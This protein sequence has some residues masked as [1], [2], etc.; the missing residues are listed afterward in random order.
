[1]FF[2]ETKTAYRIGFASISGKRFTFL[3]QLLSIDATLSIAHQN[4]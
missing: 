4:N 3:T 2:P 1:M